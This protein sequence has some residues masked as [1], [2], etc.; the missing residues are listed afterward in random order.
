MRAAMTWSRV[1]VPANHQNVLY[2]TVLANYKE[3][4]SLISALTVIP[5]TTISQEQKDNQLG[6]IEIMSVY[7]WSNLVE[8]YGDMP[9]SQ[10]SGL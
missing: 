7:A 10:S 9:Y 3:A 5:G 2:R 6:I 1:Q 8:T 4:A